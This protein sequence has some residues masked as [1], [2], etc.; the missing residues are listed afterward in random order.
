MATQRK[1]TPCYVHAP[2]VRWQVGDGNG[3]H[4]CACACMYD[5]DVGYNGAAREDCRSAGRMVLC[6][7]DG[8]RHMGNG[9]WICEMSRLEKMGKSEDEVIETHREG[10]TDSWGQG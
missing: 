9:R 2:R 10:A 4:M 5:V 3:V 1:S 8:K 6:P 7:R